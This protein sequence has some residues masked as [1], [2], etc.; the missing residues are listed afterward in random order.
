MNREKIEK[1][2]A[3]H[4]GTYLQHCISV[5]NFL[6]IDLLL[7][8]LRYKKLTPDILIVSGKHRPATDR[9]VITDILEKRCQKF[10]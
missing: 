3:L 7:L 9:T 2:L 10:L 5:I 4:G 1:V 6:Y 8:T